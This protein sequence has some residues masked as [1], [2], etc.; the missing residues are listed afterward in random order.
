MSDRIVV[1]H[2]GI[3]DQVGTPFEIYNSP[4]TRFVAGFVGTL[5]TMEAEV[6]DPASGRVRLAGTEVILHR[7]L[8]AGKVTLG[9]RPEAISLGQN[10][11]DTALTGTI[12]SVD[13]LGSVIRLRAELGGQ[14]IAFDTFNNSLTSPPQVGE[15]VVLGL[16]AADLL[17]IGD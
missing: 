9:L 5:N 3:A 16:R 13:F 10:G 1:M 6:L 15:T 2:A 7:A 11:Q 4:A 12:R 14:I 17:V 8:P